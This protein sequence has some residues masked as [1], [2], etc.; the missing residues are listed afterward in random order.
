[1]VLERKTKHANLKKSLKNSLNFWNANHRLANFEF[2][3]AANLS[4]LKALFLGVRNEL[5]KYNIIITKKWYFICH[6]KNRRF[7]NV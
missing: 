7:L 6:Q 2:L 1:M 3:H 4:D 5:K